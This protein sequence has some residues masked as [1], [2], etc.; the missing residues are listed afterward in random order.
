MRLIPPSSGAIQALALQV[1]MHIGLGVERLLL[2]SCAQEECERTCRSPAK[3]IIE[4][5]I[6]IPCHQ[7][8]DC[9]RSIRDILTLIRQHR[10]KIWQVSLGDRQPSYELEALVP[11]RLGL[12][13]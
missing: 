3:K 11:Y 8:H 4:I 1:G 6:L 5:D 9:K 12:S 7:H 10:V 13:A 2:G